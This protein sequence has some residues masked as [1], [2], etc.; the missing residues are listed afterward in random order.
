MPFVLTVCSRATSDSQDLLSKWLIPDGASQMADVERL[1]YLVL[2]MINAFRLTLLVL[3]CADIVCFIV[4]YV[5]GQ[6]EERPL[7]SL[8]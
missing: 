4:L 2:T 5:I 6:P 8:A 3:L 7:T 1:I